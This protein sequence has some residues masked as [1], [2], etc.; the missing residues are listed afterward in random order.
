LESQGLEDGMRQ[1]L[2]LGHKELNDQCKLY[3]KVLKQEDE[4]ESSDDSIVNMRAQ[5]ALPVTDR[6]AMMRRRHNESL[7]RQKEHHNFHKINSLNN[8]ICEKFEANHFFTFHFLLF[9]A[10]A[11]WELV[12]DIY[13]GIKIFNNSL[14]KAI[15]KALLGFVRLKGDY[16]DCGVTSQTMR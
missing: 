16:D 13:W 8:N 5:P 15:P 1:M 10:S 12:A 2:K 14:L 6:R 7:A 4:A 9:F 11:R 3:E